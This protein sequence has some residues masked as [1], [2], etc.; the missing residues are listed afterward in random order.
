M[1]VPSTRAASAVPCRRD[2]MG[3]SGTLSLSSVSR[4]GIVGA[5]AAYGTTSTGLLS[6]NSALASLTTRSLPVRPLETSMLAPVSRST[7]T[8]TT[9][10]CA[11][12]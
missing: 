4:A 6:A 9:W 10:D 7:M 5:E 2:P 3:G 8:E 11:W 12:R 1:R